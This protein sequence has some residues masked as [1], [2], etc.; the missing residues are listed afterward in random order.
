[1]RYLAGDTDESR[2]V[3]RDQ[4]LSATQRDFRHVGRVLE[5]LNEQGQVVVLGSQQAIES[6]NAE[7]PGWLQVIRLL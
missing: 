6:A 7:R 3:W 1:M 4:I 5:G 2:Q